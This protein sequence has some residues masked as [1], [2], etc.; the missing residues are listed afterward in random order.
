MFRHILIPTDG[1]ATSRNA[2]QQSIALAK[3]C[4][5]NVVGL[6]VIPEFHMFT[7]QTEMLED[8]REKFEKDGFAHAKK[9]L[10]EIEV[11]AKEAG[12]RCETL[13]VN[14]DSP[15]EEI[16]KVAHDKRCDLIAMASHGRKGVKGLLLGS[17]TQKVLTHSAIPVLVFR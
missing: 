8:T 14:G 13:Y 2:I 16:I 9:Y 11:A 6:Y 4:G 3:G 17:E 7:Y 1:S 12:V 15:Y 5:A 10:A